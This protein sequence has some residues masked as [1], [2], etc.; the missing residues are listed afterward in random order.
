MPVQLWSSA[1]L[2]SPGDSFE[3][4]GR[5]RRAA[6]LV[7]PGGL[8]TIEEYG[9]NWW[10]CDWRLRHKI[11]KVWAFRKADA[12]WGRRLSGICI[13]LFVDVEVRKVSVPLCGTGYGES[14]WSLRILPGRSGTC[15]PGGPS[16]EGYLD[17]S[18]RG[19][20]RALDS[21]FTEFMAQQQKELI[22]T[23][24]FISVQ[25]SEQRRSETQSAL[26]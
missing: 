11:M 4:G 16:S 3:W 12:E 8:M 9:P 6:K 2:S 25:D 10:P 17:P 13:G 18:V 19:R 22:R 14:Q 5:G 23:T 1:A 20:L 24:M 15:E 7:N 26:E 21:W